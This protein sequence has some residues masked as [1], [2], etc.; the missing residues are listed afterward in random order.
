MDMPNTLSRIA[1]VVV[2]NILLKNVGVYGKNLRC[3]HNGMSACLARVAGCW[4]L[5]RRWKLCF[6]WLLARFKLFSEIKM[7]QTDK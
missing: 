4:V 1:R 7:H 5:A 3:E 6:A 2:S